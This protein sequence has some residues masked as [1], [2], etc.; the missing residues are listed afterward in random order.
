M[1]KKELIQT[2]KNEIKN[3]SSIIRE[4]KK[5]FKH[6][7]KTYAKAPLVDSKYGKIKSIVS[8]D[9]KKIECYP[10]NKPWN[11][12]EIDGKNYFKGANWNI[13]PDIGSAKW[14]LTC[15]H[16]MYN[17]IRN[18]K[19]HCHSEERN[20]YYVQNC[21]GIMERATS[22]EEEKQDVNISSTSP[23]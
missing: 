9:Y 7:Q 22:Y 10:F 11:H 16:I 1:T 17:M 3:I 20:V 18:K 19:Q 23:A 2:I 15:L 12:L 4:N 8:E 21:K 13:N 6:N 14:H 5:N